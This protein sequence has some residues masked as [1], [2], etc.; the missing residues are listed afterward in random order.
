MLFV[1]RLIE[2]ILSIVN[3]LRKSLNR[4][5]MKRKS[6]YTFLKLLIASCENQ[7]CRIN[8]LFL[9]FKRTSKIQKKNSPRSLPSRLKRKQGKLYIMVL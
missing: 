1:I 5:L 6:S 7:I 3:I 4:G 2:S 9:H 8:I